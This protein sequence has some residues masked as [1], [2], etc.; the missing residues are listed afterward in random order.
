MKTK[1]EDIRLLV[2]QEILG[3][4]T[5]EG[6]DTLSR[7]LPKSREARRIRDDVWYVLSTDDV[8]RYI[9]A[10]NNTADI[11]IH[12]IHRQQQERVIYRSVTALIIVLLIVASVYKPDTPSKNIQLE[13]ANG[14]VI[15]LSNNKVAD[16]LVMQ[17]INKAPEYAT[18]KTPDGKDYTIRLSD[19]TEV[20]LNAATTMRFPLSFTGNKREVFINGEAFLKV[21]PN[22]D[23]PFIVHLPNST[24]FVLGTEFNVNTYN[25]ERIALITGALKVNDILLKPGQ[26]SVASVIHTFDET[27]VLSWRN[28]KFVFNNTTLEEVCKILPRIYGIAV[29]LDNKAIADKRFSG[30]IDKNKPIAHVLEALKATNGL[31]YFTDNNSVLHIK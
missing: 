18:L 16:N 30:V 22:R 17:H 7:Q 31:N 21:S 25:E 19:G 27:D 14:Q 28:G 4:L 15:N 8:Q 29:E 2:I 13:L 12:R 10:K 20:Q 24:V 6:V 5:D 9:Q 23:K 1:L 26:E 3:T 11:V